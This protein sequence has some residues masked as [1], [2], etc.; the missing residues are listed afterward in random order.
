MHEGHTEAGEAREKSR[1]YRAKNKV[2]VEEVLAE[3][4]ARTAKRVRKT[5][6]P[7]GEP[8]GSIIL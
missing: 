1:K 3:I 8:G 6:P 2:T 7:G 4:R 5:K